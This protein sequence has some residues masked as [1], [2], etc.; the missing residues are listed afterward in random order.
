MPV[1]PPPPNTSARVGEVWS[2]SVINT[3]CFP[4]HRSVL[5]THRQTYAAA[6]EA[7]LEN[8]R[9]WWQLFHRTARVD[10]H[11]VGSGAI[12]S[13]GE[14]HEAD[15][16][17]HALTLTRKMWESSASLPKMTKKCRANV[18]RGNPLGNHSRGLLGARHRPD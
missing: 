16:I 11:G 18:V 17:L 12:A 7:E 10:A 1:T 3:S 8:V 13:L 4:V 14:Q 9:T 6:M 5:A 15:R 2:W